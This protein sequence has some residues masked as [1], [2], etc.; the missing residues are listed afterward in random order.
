MEALAENES[1]RPA[2]YAEAMSLFPFKTPLAGKDTPMLMLAEIAE[3]EEI[4]RK[5]LRELSSAR[6]AVGWL[7][8]TYTKPQ[9]AG[10]GFGKRQKK[11]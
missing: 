5:R 9:F 11:Q 4:A 7:A 2:L 10:R 1:R 3:E 8:D 6:T